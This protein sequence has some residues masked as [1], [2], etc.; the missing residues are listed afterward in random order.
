MD[1]PCRKC[2]LLAGLIIF[3][4]TKNMPR[5]A[6]LVAAIMCICA[7]PVWYLLAIANDLYIHIYSSSPI[8]Y[9]ILPTACICLCYRGVCTYINPYKS[10]RT[11]KNWFVY[12]VNTLTARL[13]QQD[14]W[15]LDGRFL[16][17]VEAV[18]C[19]YFL[20]L[21]VSK[22]SLSL[23]LTLKAWGYSPMWMQPGCKTSDKQ[24][25]YL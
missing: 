7:Y 14:S 10:P 5:K 21:R 23:S 25:S 9:S 19:H 4:F 15:T 6:S 13:D 17:I 20:S 12:S 1:V 2:W 8:C 3:F 22:E 24:L 18:A 11:S 16:P